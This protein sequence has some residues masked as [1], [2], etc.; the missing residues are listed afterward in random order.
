MLGIIRHKGKTELKNGQ[1]DT[2]EK[3]ERVVFSV[4]RKVLVNA[5]TPA[6]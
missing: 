5:Q 4:R 3:A 6:V 1:E 2:R